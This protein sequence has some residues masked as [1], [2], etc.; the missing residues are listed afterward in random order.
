MNLSLMK[1]PAGFPDCAVVD[2]MV[3]IFDIQAVT[4]K[5]DTPNL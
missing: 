4:L 2:F 5:Q 3:L 1:P